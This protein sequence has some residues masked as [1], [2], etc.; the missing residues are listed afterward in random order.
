MRMIAC[1]LIFVCA[2]L[3]VGCDEKPQPGASSKTENTINSTVVQSSSDKSSSSDKLLEYIKKRDAETEKDWEKA[4]GTERLEII[5]K[6][7]TGKAY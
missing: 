7:E 4:T 1:S 6:Q 5:S 3:F 2:L